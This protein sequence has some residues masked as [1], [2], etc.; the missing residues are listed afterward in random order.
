MVVAP[1]NYEGVDFFIL[2]RVKKLH[3]I[4]EDSRPNDFGNSIEKGDEII[5]GQYYKQSSKRKSSYVLIRDKGPAFIYSHL[6]C[7]CKFFMIQ[8]THK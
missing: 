7:A 8:A 6:V 3:I 2:Q 4:E 1:G 5:I